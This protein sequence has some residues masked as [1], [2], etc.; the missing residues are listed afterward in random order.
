VRQI[1]LAIFALLLLVNPVGGQDVV[2]QA[3]ID[4]GLASALPARPASLAAAPGGGAY[5][6]AT[7]STTS[8]AS[9]AFVTRL[10]ATGGAVWS[11]TIDP[12]VPGASS[13]CWRATRPATPSSLSG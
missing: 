11:K 10:D 4:R 5:A 7:S 8:Y 9:K 12:G 3:R 1:A 6:T 13:G 2:W